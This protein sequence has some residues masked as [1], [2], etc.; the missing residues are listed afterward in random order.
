MAFAT[1]SDFSRLDG[2]TQGP[3]DLQEDLVGDVVVRAEEQPLEDLREGARLAMHVDRL[4]PVGQTR[5]AG[6]DLPLDAAAGPLDE[7]GD[8]LAGIFQKL[9]RRVLAQ[10]D[11]PATFRAPRLELAHR[12][13]RDRGA[14][15][16]SGPSCLCA[17][18]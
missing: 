7:C 12:Q 8:Q 17:R 1:F 16:R 13:R 3:P 10:A 2:S 15:R 5:G 6:R 18:R 4:Q 9:D 14:A 11:A